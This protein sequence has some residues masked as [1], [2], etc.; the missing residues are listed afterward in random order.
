LFHSNRSYETHFIKETSKKENKFDRAGQPPLGPARASDSQL[1][2]GPAPPA[3]PAS[4]A[5]FS[6][7]FFSAQPASLFTF[8]FLGRIFW[9]KFSGPFFTSSEN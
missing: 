1:Q 8:L 5:P 7:F 3:H 6:F 4:P 2:L 9:A